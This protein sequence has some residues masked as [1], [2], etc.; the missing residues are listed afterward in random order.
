MARTA[1]VADQVERFNFIPLILK[2]NRFSFISE[3]KTCTSSKKYVKCI[4]KNRT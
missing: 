1:G 4:Y 3:E 2:R